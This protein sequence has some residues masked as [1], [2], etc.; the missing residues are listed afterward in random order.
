MR[1]V[2]G[3]NLEHAPLEE[4]LEEQLGLLP[5]RACVQPCARGASDEL[6]FAMNSLEP[7]VVMRREFEL[8]PRGQNVIAILPCLVG[9][10]YHADVAL[11]GEPVVGRNRRIG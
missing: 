5:S 4:I 9:S 11:Q 3:Q 10:T 1:S 7:W 6:P 8:A 2:T